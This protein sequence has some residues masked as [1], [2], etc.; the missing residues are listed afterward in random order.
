[1][2]H[3]INKSAAY[4]SALE[5]NHCS[6]MWSL[7]LF[8]RLCSNLFWLLNCIFRQEKNNDLNQLNYYWL[9]P[10]LRLSLRHQSN[11]SKCQVIKSIYFVYVQGFSSLLHTEEKIYFDF[12]KEV[13]N[14]LF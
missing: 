3:F 2:L 9:D 11:T 8:L 1:M 6:C 4:W 10:Q 14:G 13:N 7:F 12:S 5:Y